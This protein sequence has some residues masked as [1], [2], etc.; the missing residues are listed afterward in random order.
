MNAPHP[1]RDV[2]DADHILT[3]SRSTDTEKPENRGLATTLDSHGEAEGSSGRRGSTAALGAA[4]WLSL[5]AAPTFAIIALLVAGSSDSSPLSGMVLMYVLMAAFE[6][7]AW[8]KLI[9]NRRS[10]SRKG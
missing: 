5:A 4:E 7:V 1:N 2:E 10:D 3:S 6:S 9:C 8:L